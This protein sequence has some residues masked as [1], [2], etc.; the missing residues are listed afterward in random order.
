MLESNEVDKIANTIVGLKESLA[1][2]SKESTELRKEKEELE[3]QLIKMLEDNNVSKMEIGKHKILLS[4][5]IV[6][7]V[8]DW[9]KVYQYILDEDKL[10]LLTK[11]IKAAAF[12][13]EVELREGK[14]IPGVEPFE[15]ITLSVKEI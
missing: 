13:E 12:R 14:E 11:S 6:P 5:S 1:K 4:K 7:T 2:L 3:W 15:K 10:H 8:K 9:D